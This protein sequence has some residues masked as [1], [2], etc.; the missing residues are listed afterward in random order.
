MCLHFLSCVILCRQSS[1]DG[2][3]PHARNPIKKEFIICCNSASEQVKGLICE[4]E[5]FKCGDNYMQV[6]YCNVCYNLSDWE[7]KINFFQK[8]CTGEDEGDFLTKDNFFH[9][10]KH[11]VSVVILHKLSNAKLKTNSRLKS[12]KGLQLWKSL[13]MM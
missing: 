7:L 9:I 6:T 4:R 3:I 10:Q 8:Q 2:P 13:M 5:R 1:C 11:E 12:Q